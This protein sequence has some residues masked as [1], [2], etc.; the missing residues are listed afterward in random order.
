MMDEEPSVTKTESSR[1]IQ[2]GLEHMTSSLE[3]LANQADKEHAEEQQLKK[4]ARKEPPA[5][6]ELEAPLVAPSSASAL[7]SSKA[8]EPFGGAHSG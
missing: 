6:G 5:G 7:P 8:M 3:N 2:E 4:R 1:R